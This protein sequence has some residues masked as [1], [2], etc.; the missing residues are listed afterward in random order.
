MG[1][2]FF[3]KLLQFFYFLFVPRLLVNLLL[4]FDPLFEHFFLDFKKL[5]HFVKELCWFF[6]LVELLH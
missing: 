2:A 3:K 1:I 5:F 4:K 6:E